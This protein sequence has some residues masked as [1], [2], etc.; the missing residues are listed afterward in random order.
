M[1]VSR[2][3]HFVFINAKVWSKTGFRSIMKQELSGMMFLSAVVAVVVVVVVVDMGERGREAV[4]GL[5]TEIKHNYGSKGFMPITFIEEK[6]DILRSKST[7]NQ[8]TVR[9]ELYLHA[10]SSGVHVKRS[11]EAVIIHSVAVSPDGFPSRKTSNKYFHI[12]PQAI[13]HIA[14]DIKTMPD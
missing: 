12:I 5:W 11:S 14:L 9:M 4:Q 8:G 1:G 2:Y 3:E 10:V 7:S 6:C 13:R